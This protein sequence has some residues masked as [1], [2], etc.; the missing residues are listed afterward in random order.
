MSSILD[1]LK[2]LENEQSDMQVRAAVARRI[3]D[4]EL[5]A[6]HTQANRLPDSRMKPV[7]RVITSALIALVVIGG[8]YLWR[9]SRMNAGGEP[10]TTLAIVAPIQG[11]APSVEALPEEPAEVSLEGVEPA[12]SDTAAGGGVAP[13]PQAASATSESAQPVSEAPAAPPMQVAALD[14]DAPGA[15]G[16]FGKPLSPPD[17][18]TEPLVTPEPEKAVQPEPAPEPVAVAA[19]EPVAVAAP[20]ETPQPKAAQPLVIAKADPVIVTR[21]APASVVE[22]DIA[23][24]PAIKEEGVASPPV[25]RLALEEPVALNRLPI[26]TPSEETRLGLPTITINTVAAPNERQPRP[27]A[28]INYTL[29]YLGETIPGTN[30]RLFAVDV[31]GIGLE[32][33]GT[34]YFLPKRRGR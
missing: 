30:A 15:P 21:P 24:Q 9:H 34:K 3:T 4:E 14:P 23:S 25:E 29:V 2:K 20:V 16:S 19:P 6:A 12:P 8:A 1:A 26:L 7:F 22:P 18:V 5:V 28:L 27:A 10:E 32:V 33:N 17:S 13:G 11:N 31:L